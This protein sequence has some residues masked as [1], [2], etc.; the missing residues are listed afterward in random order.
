M[1]VNR[2]ILVH[3]FQSFLLLLAMGA[4][5]VPAAAQQDVSSAYWV[6]GTTDLGS[7]VRASLRIELFNRGEDRRLITS[8]GSG[9]RA[10]LGQSAAGLI[11][12]E[13]QGRSQVTEVFTV[14]Q[15]EYEAWQ[16]GPRSLLLQSI[17]GPQGTEK[18]LPVSVI[19]R[20]I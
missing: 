1:N 3:T 16:R 10:Q 11:I 9:R 8:I 13:P 19:R 15:N 14:A 17:Q 18:I 5:V 6:V 12:L 2:Q 20:P 7:D 4:R